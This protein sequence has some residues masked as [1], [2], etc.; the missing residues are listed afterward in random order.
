MTSP[1]RAFHPRNAVTYA[2]LLLGLSATAAALHGHAA[3]AGALLALAVIADTFDGRFARL[4]PHH[5]SDEPA[6]FGVEI[7]S[8]CDACTFGMA[9]VVCTAALAAPGPPGMLCWVAGSLYMVSALTRLAFYNVTHDVVRGFI[10]LPAPV[11]ALV[12]SSA[13]WF[14]GSTDVLAGVLLG[15]AAAMVAPWRI[16]RPVG[17][18]LLVFALWPLA[19][20]AGHLVGR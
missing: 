16:P 15:A 5:G 1:A 20:V 8:L 11:A 14:T 6:A 3:T 10:G 7:D 19:V 2:G 9:P 13:L 12:W 17:A 18:G 4:F